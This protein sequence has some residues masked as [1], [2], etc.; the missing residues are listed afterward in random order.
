MN[1]TIK[2]LHI[3][4]DFRVTYFIQHEGVLISSCITQ[5]Q[6]ISLLKSD[7]LDLILSEPHNKAILN[8]KGDSKQMDLN[9]YNDLSINPKK[10][11]FVYGP[12]KKS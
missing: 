2:I 5:E 7:D 1:K 9:F 12:N 10:E 8:P 11:D 3:D 6:A 4:P